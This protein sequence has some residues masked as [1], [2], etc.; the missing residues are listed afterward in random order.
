MLLPLYGHERALG[1]RWSVVASDGGSIAESVSDE[2]LQA[3][4]EETERDRQRDYRL[5]V[6]VALVWAR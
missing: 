3:A 1:G 2:E 4:Q 5:A 6:L